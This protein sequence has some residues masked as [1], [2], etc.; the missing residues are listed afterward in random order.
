MDDL[1]IIELLERRKEEE[2]KK[3]IYSIHQ[4]EDIEY[5]DLKKS[6]AF[7]EDGVK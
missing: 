1:E 7:N 2:L 3:S 5:L 4:Q 6:G